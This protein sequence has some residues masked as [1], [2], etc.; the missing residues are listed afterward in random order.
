MS[1]PTNVGSVPADGEDAWFALHHR[2]G[3]ALP[4]GES[5]FAQPLFAEHLAFLNRLHSRGLLVAA[6]PL[7]D[8]PGAGMTI[9]R[10]PAGTEVDVHDLA[11]HDDLSVAQGLLTVEVLTWAVMFSAQQ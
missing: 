5:V 6:G 4:Q 9:V 7:P 1:D 8:R 11:T 10:I 3:P 2:P